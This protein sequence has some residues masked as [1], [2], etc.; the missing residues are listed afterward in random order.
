MGPLYIPAPPANSISQVNK[1]SH[2]F[3]NHSEYLIDLGTV[4]EGLP[5]TQR[6]HVREMHSHAFLSANDTEIELLSSVSFSHELTSVVKNAC[7]CTASV[8]P[9]TNKE[10][11]YLPISLGC[12]FLPILQHFL[13]FILQALLAGKVLFCS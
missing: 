3:K 6:G 8:H 4:F 10:T 12:S 1:E 7:V 2:P 9:H 13:L 5:S 11:N